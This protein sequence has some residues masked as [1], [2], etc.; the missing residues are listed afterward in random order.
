LR[1]RRAPTEEIQSTNEELQSANEE[2]ATVNEEL[3][4]RNAELTAS[5]NDLRN[6]LASVN[7]PILML[8]QDLKV[9]QFTPQANG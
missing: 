4:N 1:I 6:L 2:L 9:R 8:D 7:L 5:N 3:E